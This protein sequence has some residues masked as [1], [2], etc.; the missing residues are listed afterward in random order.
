MKQIN[1]HNVTILSLLATMLTFTSCIFDAPNDRF[2]RTLWECDQDP[3]D[4]FEIKEIT[5]EFLCN[6][7]VSLKTDNSTIVNYGTYESDCKNV[8]FQGLTLRADG[9]IITFID[10]QLSGDNLYLQWTIDDSTYPSTSILKRIS[11]YE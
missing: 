1:L 10:A 8:T 4:T 3:L 7:Y 5:L 9:H 2:F 11:V 6:N